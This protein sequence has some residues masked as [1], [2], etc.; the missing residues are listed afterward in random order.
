[1]L[2]S[3][4]GGGYNLRLLL[5]RV[6]GFN[7]QFTFNLDYGKIIEDHADMLFDLD[8]SLKE[9]IETTIDVIREDEKKYQKLQETGKQKMSSVVERLKQSQKP[10]E[11]KELVTLYESHGIP[12]ELA[13]DSAKKAGVEVD[14]TI[15]F[16]GEIE[17][18]N[19]KKKKEDPFVF[20]NVEKSGAKP[21]PPTRTLYYDKLY[22]DEFEAEVL[23]VNSSTAPDKT[24]VVLD[25]T[26]F[27]PEGG[28]QS[29]DTGK[30][31]GVQVTNVFKVQNWI[32]HEVEN[33]SS[34][35][36]GQRVKGFISRERRNNLMRNHTATHLLN[37]MCRKILGNH[38]WQAGAQKDWNKAHLDVTHYRK[39]TS[40]QAEEIEKLVNEHIQK[41]IPVHKHVL[42]R[43]EAEQK[44][45]FRIYQGGFVP[46]KELRVIEIEGIDVQ[47]CGGTHINNTGEI[48]FFKILKIESVQDGIERIVFA[49][50]IPALKV[51]QEK[52]KVLKKVSADLNVPEHD[53]VV[54]TKKILENYKKAR[55]K[56]AELQEYY[57][58]GVAN[59]LK[60]HIKGS[61]LVRLVENDDVNA[62]NLTQLAQILVN[63]NPTLGVVLVGKASK[64]A[65][66]MSGKASEFDAKKAIQL[67]LSHAKGSGGGSNKVGQAKLVSLDGIE[68]ALMQL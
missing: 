20:W 32:L 57:L 56:T 40:G 2:P 46:G 11:K 64:M 47:A 6:F 44:Y 53:L 18:K 68:A 43:G 55:K 61:K 29:Y 5:R 1:M 9:S 67:V 45:G 28:G 8:N 50:G 3:N 38:I 35:S 51:I 17:T 27:Y 49:T 16:Y 22:E 66:A 12:F 34:F 7:S 30:L 42:D 63:E 26:L 21:V 19:E 4:A 13:V 65:V 54:G 10:L 37:A 33:G 31:N 60:F 59:E 25:Q 36:E 62:E 24:F 41:M 23:Q 48:G 52:E 15:D 14:D 39:I 58:K